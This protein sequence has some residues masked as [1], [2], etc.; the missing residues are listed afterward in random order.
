VHWWLY[1]FA[2]PIGGVASAAGDNGAP[3]VIYQLVQW[4]LSLGAMAGPGLPVFARD[5][6]VVFCGLPLVWRALGHSA[7]YRSGGRAG[8]RFGS[9]SLSEETAGSRG[10]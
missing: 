4:R 3:L 5:D 2:Y 7:D 9:H 8:H 1:A 10:R 6:A